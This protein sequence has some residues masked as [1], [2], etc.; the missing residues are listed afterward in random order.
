MGWIDGWRKKHE[1]TP[2][3]L[4]SELPIDARQELVAGMAAEAVE[5]GDLA[6]LWQLVDS[7]ER[8]GDYTVAEKWLKE[9]V[10][11]HDPEALLRLGLLYSQQGDVRQ[12]I[13]WCRQA[14]AKGNSAA[15]WNL[16]VQYFKAG[17]R[18]EAVLWYTKAAEAGDVDAMEKITGECLQDG[19][20]EVALRW[21]SRAAEAGSPTAL[22]ME[23]ALASALRGDANAAAI[24]GDSMLNTEN[25]QQAAY[26]YRKAADAGHT[27]SAL[28]LGGIIGTPAF[29]DWLGEGIKKGNPAARAVLRQLREDD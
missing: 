20:P 22:A 17:D 13:E 27:Q 16:G 28:A 9:I 8:A 3:Q 21:A 24:L 23:G 14:A 1:T 4:I 6:S 18:R 5:D 15:M 19:N 7:A 11:L 2:D 10:G 29:A 26:W 12:A 25:E